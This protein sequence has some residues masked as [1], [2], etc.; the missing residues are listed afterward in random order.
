VIYQNFN[1]QKVLD[2]FRDFLYFVR[3]IYAYCIASYVD[4]L[5]CLPGSSIS[6]VVVVVCHHIG[7]RSFWYGFPSY[8]HYEIQSS[9]H[10]T[11]GG[12]YW[13]LRRINLKGRKR[14]INIG[15]K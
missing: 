5:L 4:Y 14:A 10:T 3:R 2:I 9:K 6:L 13:K 15:E 7:V 12:N 1:N 11:Y 8:I